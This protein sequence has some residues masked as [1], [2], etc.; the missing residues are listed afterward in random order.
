MNHS[1]GWSE[2]GMAHAERRQELIEAAVELFLQY[3]Y[4]KTTLDDLG[5]RVGLTKSSLYHYFSG[6]EDLYRSVAT[7]VFEVNLA[8]FKAALATGETSLVSLLALAR[9]MSEARSEMKPMDFFISGDFGELFAIVRGEVDWYISEMVALVSARL[10]RAQQ[11]GEL[12][13][14]MPSEDMARIYMA[15][16]GQVLEARDLS[17]QLGEM[18]DHLDRYLRLLLQPWLLPGWQPGEKSA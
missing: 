13:E 9:S 2:E 1:F 7:K 11:E 16:I 12:S 3:G 4:R 14:E 10:K 15:L 6:K 8:K 17:S 5:E 18:A